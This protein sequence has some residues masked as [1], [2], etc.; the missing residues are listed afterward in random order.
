M[1][2]FART[3]PLHWVSGGC[4]KAIQQK[5]PA[6]YLLDLCNHL[7]RIDLCKIYRASTTHKGSSSLERVLG[8]N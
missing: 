5:V 2:T 4:S 1:R 6:I 7:R 8:I 3:K